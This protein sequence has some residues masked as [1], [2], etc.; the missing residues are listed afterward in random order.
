MTASRRPQVAAEGFGV[1]G[2]AL[3][4]WRR[5]AEAAEFREPTAAMT[6]WQIPDRKFLNSA[7]EPL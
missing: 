4:R 2:L 3:R 5:Q 6:R 1:I 7:R